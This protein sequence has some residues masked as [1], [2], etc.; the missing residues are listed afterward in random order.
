MVN[1]LVLDF[2]R[3]T[4]AQ[5]EKARPGSIDA[6]RAH[7]G[8]LAMLSDECR[9]EHLELKAFLGDHVYRHYASASHDVESTIGFCRSF[10]S[11]F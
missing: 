4:Q 7:A 8:P 5:I 3:T 1:H 11:H 9:E 10:F 2:I 6:V